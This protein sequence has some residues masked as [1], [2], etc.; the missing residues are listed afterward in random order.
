MLETASM[1]LL[2][3]KR[4]IYVTDQGSNVVKACKLSDVERFG[5]IAHGLHNLIMADGVSKCELA[6]GIIDKVKGVIN[7]FTFKNALIESEASDSANERAI[8]ELEVLCEQLDMDEQIGQEGDEDTDAEQETSK[9]K[10]GK[11]TT[12]KKNTAP[13]GGILCTRC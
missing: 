3:N 5:C 13:R 12:L 9:C 7:T 6:Q 8:Q 10:Q 11:A 1:F 4:I 2:L